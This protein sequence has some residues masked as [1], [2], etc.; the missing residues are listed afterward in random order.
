MTSKRLPF[1][2]LGLE[3]VFIM[4]FFSVLLFHVMKVSF[5]PF[6]VAWSSE[7]FDY[8]ILL[9]LGGLTGMA[10]FLLRQRFPKT[11]AEH[12]KMTELYKT[13]TKE[14]VLHARQ[15]LRVPASIILELS[16][17]MFIAIGIYAIWD[18]KIALLQESMPWAGKALVIL[19]LMVIAVYGYWRFTKP[20]Q[21]S[22]SF[23]ETAAR[24][25][26]KRDKKK[27]KVVKKLGK[28]AG[29]K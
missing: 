4:A 12:G 16:V 14:K 17:I 24:P 10:Y 8:F 29:K 5:S 6:A 23:Y 7:G 25:L 21:Q 3:L 13:R 28:K 26:S 20:F 22:G 18:E 19:G 1:A 15:D 27:I 9:V 2:L 11:L